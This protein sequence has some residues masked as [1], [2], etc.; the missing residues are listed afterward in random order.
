[1]YM[2]APQSHVDCS[3]YINYGW[4]TDN[5]WL[6][7]RQVNKTFSCANYRKWRWDPQIFDIMESV[8]YL[9]DAKRPG[10]ETGLSFQ[11]CVDVHNA[12][13]RKLVPTWVSM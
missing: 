3:R 2:C 12:L 8:D 10:R 7:S 1:M 6:D 5:S 13:S 4:N 9:P 11:F